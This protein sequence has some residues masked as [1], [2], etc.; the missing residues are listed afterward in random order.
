MSKEKYVFLAYL[1]RT[2]IEHP[3]WFSESIEVLSKALQDS[4][5]V[6]RR[7][8]SRYYD[9]MVAALSLVK[10]KRLSDKLKDHFNSEILDVLKLSESQSLF[11]QSVID[12]LEDWRGE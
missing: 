9:G 5:V 2:I 11:T 10:E 6:A 8:Q 1:S 12:E 4:V 3:E 7:K